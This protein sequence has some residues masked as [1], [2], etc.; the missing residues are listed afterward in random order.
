MHD[1]DVTRHAKEVTT[2]RTAGKPAKARCMTPGALRDWIPA[3]LHGELEAVW[4]VAARL[5]A[6]SPSPF[7]GIWPSHVLAAIADRDVAPWLGTALFLGS[8]PVGQGGRPDL[9]RL[10]DEERDWNRHAVLL[11]DLARRF[12]EALREPLEALPSQLRPR[13]VSDWGTNSAIDRRIPEA[14]AA[15]E[16]GE[17]AQ[18]VDLLLRLW[19]E[20][21]D[22]L[23]AD[24]IDVLDPW[25]SPAFSVQMAKA[26]WQPTGA[27]RKDAHTGPALRSGFLHAADAAIKDITPFL[28]TMATEPADPRIATA[29]RAALLVRE[30][31]SNTSFQ[32]GRTLARIGDVR[33]L[34]R[35]A[36]E[37]HLPSLA[38]A[39]M[40]TIAVGPAARQR[41]VKLARRAAGGS[42][43]G[44]KTVNLLRRQA[45]AASPDQRPLAVAVLADAARENGDT[46]WPPLARP[47]RLA[48]LH[49]LQIEALADRPYGVRTAQALYC[50]GL[51]LQGEPTDAEIA[52]LDP[53]WRPI[54]RIVVDGLDP[55]MLARLPNLT[56]IEVRVPVSASPEAC[57]AFLTEV[58]RGRSD[59]IRVVADASGMFARIP[60]AHIAAV[61]RRTLRIGALLAQTQVA[62]LALIASP[63]ALKA[64]L[65]NAQAPITRVTLCEAGRPI[66]AP[67]GWSLTV[68]FETRAL[69]LQWSHGIA[70]TTIADVLALPATTFASVQVTVPADFPELG[71]LR[72]KLR[73]GPATLIIA[74]APSRRS[75]HRSSQ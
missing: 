69:T 42:E 12:G 57:A 61:T 53:A 29:I 68:D 71:P 74:P 47:V 27:D 5:L 38:A 36:W 51:L 56:G 23:V 58:Q 44:A 34:P 37:H 28:D 31:R 4:P 72:N 67:I 49:A 2:R 40:W 50:D 20:G 22:P 39:G 60:G 64:V 33:G 41:L 10:W 66:W 55:S 13:I 24:V 48:D 46:D 11:G 14:E 7:V 73:G 63:R 54:E 19:R 43:S 59:P 8:D 26:Y 75:S 25:T 18:A 70:V 45:W 6:A 32:A 17:R 3:P 15:W 52:V 30:P 35:I 9:V 1:G 62:H 21:G 16:A 65:D